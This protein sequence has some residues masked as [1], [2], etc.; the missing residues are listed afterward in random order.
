MNAPLVERYRERI[1]GVLTCYDRA[2]IAGTLPGA[3][4]AAGMTSFLNARHIRI[5]TI[6]ALPNRFATASG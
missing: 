4:H 2:V 1:A 3:C 5:L 6:P